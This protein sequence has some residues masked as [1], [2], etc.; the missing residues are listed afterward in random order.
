MEEAVLDIRDDLRATMAPA[1]GSSIPDAV[2]GPA[3]PA[4]DATDAETTDQTNPEKQNDTELEA[5]RQDVFTCYPPRQETRPLSKPLPIRP[6]QA[7]PEGDAIDNAPLSEADGPPS[8]Q[9]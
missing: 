9:D 2:A 8:R 7:M 6:K 1:G 4:S 5:T 3:E